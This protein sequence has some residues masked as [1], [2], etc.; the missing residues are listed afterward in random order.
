VINRK[1]YNC[2]F[3]TN[4]SSR[5]IYLPR[6][7]FRWLGK[8]VAFNWWRIFNH[9]RTFRLRTSRFLSWLVI[10]KI[11]LNYLI[12]KLLNFHFLQHT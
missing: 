7:L 8:L 12:P 1:T 5:F 11:M 10:Q 3:V 9:G 4:I 2:K 6:L